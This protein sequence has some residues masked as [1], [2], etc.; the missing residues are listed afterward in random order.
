LTDESA[1]SRWF[2]LGLP[3]LVVLGLALVAIVVGYVLLDRGSVTAA[4]VLL[5]VG[6]VILIPLALLLGYRRLGGAGEKGAAEA[7]G[8]RDDVARGGRGKARTTGEG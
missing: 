8:E 6:Y 7:D 2:G 3:N 4:P 5:V 1:D